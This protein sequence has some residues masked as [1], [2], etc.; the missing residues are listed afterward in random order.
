MNSDP[1]R[2]TDWHTRHRTL[3]LTARMHANIHLPESDSRPDSAGRDTG[4]PEPLSPDRNT[5]LRHPDAD[6]SPNACIEASDFDPSRIQQRHRP[7][8]R[9]RHT[10]R[11]GKISVDTSYTNLPRASG[12]I[13]SGYGS[14]SAMEKE[15]PVAFL[16][17][18]RGLSE[19]PSSSPNSSMAKGVR[20]SEDLVLEK[21]R[22]SSDSIERRKGGGFMGR[23]HSFRHRSH[24]SRV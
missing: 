4:F 6:T 14:A 24:G 13:D 19:S 5:T 22:G 21:I 17:G 20:H 8:L 3:S 23:L 12:T 11:H 1:A 18:S 16:P 2:I 7:F 15:G 9:E 10:S